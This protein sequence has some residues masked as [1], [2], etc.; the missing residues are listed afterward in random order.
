MIES[1]FVSS[2]AGQVPRAI[3]K[4]VAPV[5]DEFEIEAKMPIDPDSIPKAARV[6]RTVEPSKPASREESEVENDV[7][8]EGEGGEI[9]SGG[10]EPAVDISTVGE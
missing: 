6:V 5:A 3:P 7:D 9:P 2:P 4:V 8:E 10:T 1:R